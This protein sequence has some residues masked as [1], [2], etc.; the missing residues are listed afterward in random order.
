MKCHR[1]R[2]LLILFTLLLASC[3][4][5]QFATLSTSDTITQQVPPLP[6][7]KNIELLPENFQVLYTGGGSVNFANGVMDFYPATA[8]ALTQTH[9]PLIFL[10]ETQDQPVMN[11]ELIVDVT[12]VAQLRQGSAPNPWEVF[13]IF[14]NYTG[15]ISDKATNY[16]L[17]K[18]APY[19]NELGVAT[20]RVGQEFLGSDGN[21]PTAVGERHV[22]TYKRKGAK[23]TVW[24]DSQMIY[25]YQDTGGKLLSTKGAIAFYCEDAH[26]Q[27]HSVQYR[28]LDSVP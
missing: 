6:D 9:A 10:K 14:F 11:F 23:F 27:I 26:V 19:G 2:R 1:H 8:F 4:M 24:R 20:D 25:N 18:P 3:G 22:F 16:Y 21:F 28:G 7:F 5:N 15:G 13:W 17:S 12:T